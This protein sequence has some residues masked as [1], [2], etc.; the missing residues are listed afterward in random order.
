MLVYFYQK[1]LYYLNII[2]KIVFIIKFGFKNLQ[3]LILLKIDYISNI[4]KMMI[5]I[6][7][8]KKDIIFKIYL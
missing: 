1:S 4:K 5:F 8:V 2:Y 7:S 3:F 6:N